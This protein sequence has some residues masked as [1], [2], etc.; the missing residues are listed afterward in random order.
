MRWHRRLSW[1]NRYLEH[2]SAEIVE[3]QK[4]APAKKRLS[5]S[6]TKEEAFWSTI[7]EPVQ[8][9][10]NVEIEPDDTILSEFQSCTTLCRR[11]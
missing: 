9:L 6:S 7:L 2:S 3:N 8:S 11:R 5:I 10:E 4:K 1:K